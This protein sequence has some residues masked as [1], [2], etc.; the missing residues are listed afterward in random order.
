VRKY[1]PKEQENNSN[2]GFFLLILYTAFIFIR[3]HEW[4]LNPIEFPFIRILLITTFVFY[5]VQQKP[6]VWGVQAWCL[7]GLVVVMVLSGIRNYWLTGG[8]DAA[9]TFII[10]AFIPFVLISSLLAENKKINL[11]LFVIL[12]STLFMLHHS[13]IQSISAGGIAWSGMSAYGGEGGRVRYLGFFND[14]NDL[15][16]FLLMNIPIAFYFRSISKSFI[17]RM[18]MLAWILMLLYGIYLTNSRGTMLGLF[19]LAGAYTFFRFGKVKAFILL[20]IC[21]PIAFV[22][23]NQFR[24]IDSGESSAQG[25][26]E[27]WYEGVQ[28]FKYRPLLGVGKGNFTEHH[29]RTAHNSYVLVMAELGVLG[30]S[31]WFVFIVFTVRKLLLIINKKIAI[32]EDKLDDWEE[33]ATKYQ[34]LALTLFYCFVGYLTTAFFLSRSF[35]VVLFV[36]VGIATALISA[37]ERKYIPKDELVAMNG[38]IISTTVIIAIISLALL[39]FVVVLLL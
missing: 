22:V 28:M 2:F 13:Y 36:F 23:M 32:P 33:E 7:L 8:I 29:H 3:P 25:R 4:S 38:K 11:F 16:M 12:I 26:I 27:A 6:K 24:E 10:S 19:S 37:I 1:K 9:T 20:G 17:I 15:G 5:L 31:F 39:Y 35:V 14:P 18:I 30:Y 34:A 21:I